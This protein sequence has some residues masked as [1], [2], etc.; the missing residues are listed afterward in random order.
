M[1]SVR[2]V[3]HRL[4]WAALR[5]ACALAQSLGPDR[6]SDLGDRIG[7]LLG[8][9]IPAGRGASRRLARIFP[10]LAE[11][12]R[13]RILSA[14]F[15]NFG[16]VAFEFPHLAR[17]G[18][19]DRIEIE[20]ARH[21]V[22]AIAIGRG[23][24]VVSAHF[25]NGEL[26]DFVAARLGAPLLQIVRRAN[27]PHVEALVSRLRRAKPGTHAPKGAEGARQLLSAL[28]AGRWVGLMIDQ[29]QNDGIEVPFLGRPTR[30][31]EAAAR[32][33]I[34]FGA[35]IVPMRV[36]RIAG[37][38]FRAHI[39]PVVLAASDDDPAEITRRLAVIAEGWI[40]ARPE[41]WFW[42]H[43]RWND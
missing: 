3:R 26:C 25:G 36:E 23:G 39:E 33:A 11:R 32:L 13:A 10:E 35:P 2:P 20:G 16:R 38:R 30:M 21:L 9:A 29:K 43:N 14:M 37:A 27:N 8:P 24:I 1:P 7:R 34:R 12:D 41:Q 28:A 5:L 40:R 18:E 4:E 15:G 42:L 31:T 17:F 19:P 22:D 6:A